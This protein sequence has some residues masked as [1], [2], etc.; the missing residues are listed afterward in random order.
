ML[1]VAAKNVWFATIGFYLNHGLN[2]VFNGSPMY[3]IDPLCN[4]CH[5][6]SMLSVNT[7]NIAIITVKNVDYR[8]II[9]NSKS[10]A[11]NLLKNRVLEDRG[12]I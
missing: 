7:S 9:H 5:D 6:L 12:Y 3:V 8:C 4:G 11:V 10:E 2:H 1:K